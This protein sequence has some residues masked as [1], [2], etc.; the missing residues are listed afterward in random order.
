MDLENRMTIKDF[1]FR[2]TI[3]VVRSPTDGEEQASEPTDQV[4]NGKG[5]SREDA[6]WTE[7]REGI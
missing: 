2:K 7:K 4:K 5:A 3:P 1:K 6:P